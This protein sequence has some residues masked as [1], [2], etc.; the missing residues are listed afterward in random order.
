MRKETLYQRAT[1]E[2]NVLIR[3]LLDLSGRTSGFTTPPDDIWSDKKAAGMLLGGLGYH[4]DAMGSREQRRNAWLARAAM[5]FSIEHAATTILYQRLQP[6]IDRLIDTAYRETNSFRTV[7]PEWIYNNA[8]L[9]PVM[10]HAVGTFSKQELSR[11]VGTVSDTGISRP[12][13][14][15]LAELISSVHAGAIAQPLRPYQ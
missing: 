11:L 5:P 1:K 9:L 6:F 14:Q 15:R 13:S 8:H 4:P 7:T 2:M 12:A 3:S 10:M